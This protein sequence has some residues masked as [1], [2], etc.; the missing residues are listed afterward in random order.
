MTL[1]AAIAAVCW[2]GHQRSRDL[3]EKIVQSEVDLQTFETQKRTTEA[4]LAHSTA[5]LDFC[6]EIAKAHQPAVEG[7]ADIQKRYGVVE[8]SPNGA[9]IRSV[10]TLRESAHQNRT[11]YR[12]S[13][14][15]QPAVFLRSAIA[16]ESAVSS[17]NRRKLDDQDWRQDSPMS[18][19]PKSQIQ[20]PPGIHDLHITVQQYRNQ[21]GNAAIELKLDGQL[22]ANCVSESPKR[23][24]GSSSFSSPRKQYDV[25]FDRGTHFLMEIEINSEKV[26]NQHDFEFW[27]WLS[28]NAAVEFDDYPGSKPG[29]SSD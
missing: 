6:A 3:V 23:S 24:I 11:H 21:S 10:P 22:L 26:P 12:I 14:P 13:V 7:F 27:I 1:I 5:R 16:T 4:A 20:I 28:D 29:G 25:V 17:R 19:S 2:R 15:D 18:S 8:P 9:R